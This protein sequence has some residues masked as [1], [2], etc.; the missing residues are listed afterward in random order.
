MGSVYHG[1]HIDAY[2][3][4]VAFTNLQEWTY[5]INV[6]TAESTSAVTY[7]A[8]TYGKTRDTGF[9]GG[10]ASVTCL[11]AGDLQAREGEEYT[12][13]LLR[14]GA[15][16]AKGIEGTAICTGASVSTS[17]SDEET[18]TYSFVFNGEITGTVT[19]GS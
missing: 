17:K 4:S 10:T 2:W 14:T 18:V 16:A 9:K 5:T 15:N 8:M 3:N 19:E 6:E 11:V 1:K 12:L 7:G 13:E